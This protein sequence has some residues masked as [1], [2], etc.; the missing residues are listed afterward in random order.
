M[1]NKEVR[2]PKEKPQVHGRAYTIY[3]R[4]QAEK[5]RQNASTMNLNFKFEDIIKICNVFKIDIKEATSRELVE[6]ICSNLLGRKN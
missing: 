6:K 2:K 5:L 1:A 4:I 3:E